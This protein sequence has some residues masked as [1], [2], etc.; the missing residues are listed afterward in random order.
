[1]WLLHLFSKNTHNSHLPV[2]VSHLLSIHS[3]IHSLLSNR[4]R[5]EKLSKIT[6]SSSFIHS[7]IHPYRQKKFFKIHFASQLCQSICLEIY[8]THTFFLLIFSPLIGAHYIISVFN[9][10]FEFFFFFAELSEIFFL[11]FRSI[12]FGI[13]FCK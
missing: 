2:I 8:S 9:S 1:M 13:L 5:K 6:D 10:K 12:S 11:L 3:F 4:N 7:T